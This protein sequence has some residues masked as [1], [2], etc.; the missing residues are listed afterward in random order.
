MLLAGGDVG[1]FVRIQSLETQIPGQFSLSLHNALC[2]S[3][4][5]WSESM[6]IRGGVSKV[7]KIVAA[8]S[9]F[10]RPKY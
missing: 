7:R 1:I 2:L 10:R 3:L 6:Q 4:L 8:C 9:M 5:R